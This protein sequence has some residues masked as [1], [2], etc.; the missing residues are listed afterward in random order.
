MAP[1]EQENMFKPD[2]TLYDKF[3]N[4]HAHREV[5]KLGPGVNKATIVTEGRAAWG[6]IWKETYKV[7]LKVIKTLRKA[8][9]GEVTVMWAD[10]GFDSDLD[11][12]SS[13][14]EVV[15]VPPPV[16]VVINSTSTDSIK[17]N[18]VKQKGFHNVRINHDRVRNSPSVLAGY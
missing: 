7:K 11:D 17:P 15:F 12:Q 6:K 5:I 13:D 3:M 1:P 9:I 8:K 10:D 14:D 16:P 4:A 18:A 2:K